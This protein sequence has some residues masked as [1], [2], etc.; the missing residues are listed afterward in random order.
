[1]YYY[2]IKFSPMQ[3]ASSG[4]GNASK[5]KMTVGKQAICNLTINCQWLIYESKNQISFYE[6]RFHKTKLLGMRQVVWDCVRTTPQIC[7]QAMLCC[8]RAVPPRVYRSLLSPESLLLS[9]AC[10]GSI[11]QAKGIPLWT[12]IASHVSQLS[13]HLLL[14]GLLFWFL[15][16][17]QY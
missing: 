13:G 4:Q 16:V 1:M 17:I 12:L 5:C 2:Y 10:N 14:L 15:L 11:R 8:H 3:R 7:A 9:Y 6:T